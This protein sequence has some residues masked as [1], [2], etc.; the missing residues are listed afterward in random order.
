MKFYLKNYMKF[1]LKNAFEVNCFIWNSMFNFMWNKTRERAGITVSIEENAML[2]VIVRLILINKFC[3]DAKIYVFRAMR[4][5]ILSFVTIKHNE[6]YSQMH[7]TKFCALK[8][9][10]LNIFKKCKFEKI[11]NKKIY[12]FGT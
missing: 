4:C 2:D 1:Y 8:K 7:S 11:V 9:W 5:N 10:L 3:C 12:N 6:N